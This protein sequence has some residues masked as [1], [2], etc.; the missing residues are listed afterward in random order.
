[1]PFFKPGDVVSVIE[2]LSL[3]EKYGSDG[4]IPTCCV[5][6]SMMGFAG[7]KVTIADI[8]TYPDRDVVR[9]HIKE[10]N[11][12]WVWTDEMFEEYY[13][14]PLDVEPPSEEEVFSFLLSD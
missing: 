2:T 14:T 11:G 13:M 1:M 7:K 9:Y 4:E 10:D 5:A 8:R 12:S 6:P 3:K